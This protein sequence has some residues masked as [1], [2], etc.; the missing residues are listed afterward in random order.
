MTDWILTVTALGIYGTIAAV[1]YVE[2]IRREIHQA[3]TERDA[4]HRDNVDK[5]T[6]LKSNAEFELVRTIFRSQN[7][8]D[9]FVQTTG[10]T[11][12]S[13][14]S[15]SDGNSP[16]K[17]DLKSVEKE[18]ADITAGIKLVSEPEDLFNS[19]CS[20]YNSKINLIESLANRL[21]VASLAI[22]VAIIL[23]SVEPASDYSG[24]VIGAIYFGLLFG[25]F[26]S[27][28][29]AKEYREVSKRLSTNPGK[30]EK[31][32]EQRIFHLGE[33]PTEAPPQLPPG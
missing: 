18:I 14:L 31:L 10:G 30:F 17:L 29:R 32:V 7:L 6:R 24:I 25:I 4:F 11:P 27:G 28:T 2:G 5:V 19:I 9:L 15:E 21:F 23:F 26:V 16:A 1:I 13:K 12:S 3:R 8:R 33:S 22:P 20:D